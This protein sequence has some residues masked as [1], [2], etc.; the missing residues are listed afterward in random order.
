MA[1]RIRWAR[2]SAGL[3]QE[4]LAEV[5]GTSRRHVIRW[6]QGTRPGAYYRK[7]LARATGQPELLFEA[8]NGGTDGR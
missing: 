5:V 8:E 6:E 7:R 4:K 3:S 2:K 1:F